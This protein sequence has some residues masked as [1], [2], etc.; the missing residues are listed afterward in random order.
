[1]L[2]VLIVIVVVAVLAAILIPVSSRVQEYAHQSTCFSN[3][4]QLGRSLMQYSQD[5]NGQMCKAWEGNSGF[6]AS[7]PRKGTVKYKWMDCLYP[8]VKTTD[9]FSCPDFD[10]DLKLGATGNYV[11]Y[12]QLGSTSE[13]AVPDDTHYGSYAMNASYSGAAYNNFGFMSP[14]ASSG[15]GGINSTPASALAHPATTAWIVDGEGG[16]QFDWSDTNPAPVT[17]A[18][19]VQTLGGGDLQNGSMAARHSGLVGVLWCDGHT[20]AMSITELMTT[21]TVTSKVGARKTV[22]PYLVVEDYGM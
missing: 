3:M 5:Y 7:D 22:S 2:E 1:M 13:T 14:G 21:R 10:D 6:Q 19:G 4:Q 20:K 8:Y 18:N 16:F 15:P 17:A 12:Q 11:P 9:V